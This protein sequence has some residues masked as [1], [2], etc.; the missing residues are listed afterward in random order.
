LTRRHLQAFEAHV[1]RVHESDEFKAKAREAQP[2]FHGVRDFIFGRPATL[3][4]IVRALV[5]LPS[6]FS[7]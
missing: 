3:E 4:N 2:F 1:E 5:L 7:D 6:P